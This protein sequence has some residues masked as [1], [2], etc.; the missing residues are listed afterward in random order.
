MARADFVT[1]YLGF[2]PKT[3]IYSQSPKIPLVGEC[4]ASHTFRASKILAFPIQKF[5]GLS[6]P[7]LLDASPMVCPL[8][9]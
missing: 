7:V 3:F 1:K 2:P 8:K 4:L 5:S 9:I 6:F